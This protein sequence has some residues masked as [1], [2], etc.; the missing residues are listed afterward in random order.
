MPSKTDTILPSWNLYFSRRDCLTP[1]KMI[2][3]YDAELVLHVGHCACDVVVNKVDLVLPLHA[4]GT[5]ST[6]GARRV[7]M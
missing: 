1:R 4:P 2:V 7:K 3:V 6:G 5:Q